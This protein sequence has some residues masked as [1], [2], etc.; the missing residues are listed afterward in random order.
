MDRRIY[1]ILGAGNGGQAMAGYLALH[2][3]EVRLWNRSPA[4]LAHVWASGGVPVLG[5]ITGFG[6][7]A[8]A[9]TDLAQAVRGADVL[10]AVVPAT[11]HRTLA[12]SLARHV[13][14]GQILLINPGRTGGDL[15]VQKSVSVAAVPAE[16]TPRVIAALGG[17]FPQFCPAASV[18]ETSLDNMGAIFHPGVTL[19]NAARIEATGGD[20]DYY[21]HGVTPAVARVLEQI[22]NERMEV[23]AAYGVQSRSAREWLDDAYAAKG[24]TLREAVLN[25]AGYAGIKA[26]A[27]LNHRYIWEDVPTSLVPIAD[28]G[29]IAGVPTPTIDAMIDLASALHGI[30]YRREGRNAAA[31]GIAG[32]SVGQV[33]QM[34]REGEMTFGQARYQLDAPA[35]G[36]MPR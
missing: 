13:A 31:M 33:E 17:A 5:A 27:H 11:A 34:I 35:A 12:L 28:L 21:H 22:D 20:F 15:E 25:N 14:P 3:Y 9:T 23:A 36:D 26:P 29:R 19:L 32:M 30:D 2:G 16:D 18:L 7:V 4:R 8:V 24:E 1:A 6:R 10:M